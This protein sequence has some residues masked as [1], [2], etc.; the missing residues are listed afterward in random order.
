MAPC[1]NRFTNIG[2]MANKL[3]HHHFKVRER[4]QSFSNASTEVEK[5]I[6]EEKYAIEIE[7]TKNRNN[8][9]LK[10]KDGLKLKQ[11]MIHSLSNQIVC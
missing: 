11:S 7:K 2:T 6:E 10:V 4:F 9:I 5:M 1:C 8:A 3:L